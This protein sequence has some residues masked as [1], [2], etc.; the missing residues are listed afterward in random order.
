M[1]ILRQ[2]S[3]FTE[4][5]SKKR[6]KGKILFFRFVSKEKLRWLKDWL[7]TLISFLVFL[8]FLNLKMCDQDWLNG[9]IS[10]SYRQLAFMVSEAGFRRDSWD[11]QLELTEKLIGI[12]EL[13]MK[14]RVSERERNLQ[15][16]DGMIDDFLALVGLP[17]NER[18]SR[19]VKLA[20]FKDVLEE[21][22]GIHQA[23]RRSSGIKTIWRRTNL[24]ATVPREHDDTSLEMADGVPE[25]K[26]EME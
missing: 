11:R 23:K 16:K 10:L 9:K 8:P 17:Y 22:L 20:R 15:L 3:H 21:T 18:E 1:K 6:Q 5:L 14:V 13:A 12:V 24:V 19:N 7:R 25:T 4:I 26:A 2:I